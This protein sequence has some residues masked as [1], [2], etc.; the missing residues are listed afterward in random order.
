VKLI[1]NP[2]I[3][4]VSI[5][6]STPLSFLFRAL[7]TITYYIVLI[8][9]SVIV[10]FLRVRRSKDSS[11][12]TAGDTSN[13][14]VSIGFTRDI[15]VYEDPNAFRTHKYVL[16]I[17]KRS[18]SMG[19]ESTVVAASVYLPEKLLDPHFLFVSGYHH[20]LSRI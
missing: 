16:D 14:S 5:Y 19:P 2:V 6:V 13:V 20:H 3:P 11:S 8:L 15:H 17:S 10:G 9:V 1:C 7:L 4:F 18:D 12:T